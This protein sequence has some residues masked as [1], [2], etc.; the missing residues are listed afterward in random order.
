MTCVLRISGPILSTALAQV[1][2]TPYRV[3][4]GHA[5]FTTSQ[6]DMDDL[7]GQVRDTVAFILANRSAI[8]T[9]MASPGTSGELDFAT[10]YEPGAFTSRSVSA[11]LVRLAGELG[12]GITVSG[13]PSC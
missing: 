2:I 4:N 12:L 9:L 8:E 7:A 3:E 13:Y 10:E 11:A 5:H 1:S 6:P